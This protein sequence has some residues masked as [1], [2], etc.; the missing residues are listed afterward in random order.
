ME[1]IYR[2]YTLCIWPDSKPT[3]FLYHSKQKPRRWGG[4]RWINT[5]CRVPLQVNYKKRRYLGLE[6]ISY[7]VHGR[8]SP[9]V[10]TKYTSFKIANIIR[11]GFIT[12]HVTKIFWAQYP[13]YFLL[14]VRQ[15]SFI[16]TF[17]KNSPYSFCLIDYIVQGPRLIFRDG[18]SYWH[19]S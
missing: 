4:L 2:S 11:P 5:C 9:G 12:F 13:P 1:S 15:H 19:G 6:S 17:N 10:Y 3:K 18:V 7:L 14:F 16:K 8:N